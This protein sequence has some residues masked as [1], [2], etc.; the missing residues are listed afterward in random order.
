MVTVPDLDDQQDWL[1]VRDFKHLH[2]LNEEGHFDLGASILKQWPSL[3]TCGITECVS[4]FRPSPIAG[5]PKYCTACRGWHR[6]HETHQ[7]RPGLLLPPSGFPIHWAAYSDP[8]D[9]MP[10]REYMRSKYGIQVDEKLGIKFTVRFRVDGHHPLCTVPRHLP[11]GGG[12][13]P[14]VIAVSTRDEPHYFFCKKL[15]VKTDHT[16][17]TV[18]VSVRLDQS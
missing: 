18:N 11:P 4:S 12:L 2:V 5:E 14:S 1:F 6:L 8:D 17:N 15:I 10:P 16:D 3:K 7:A 13:P 9:P